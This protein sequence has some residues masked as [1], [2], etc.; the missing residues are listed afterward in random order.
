MRETEASRK[1]R[2]YLRRLTSRTGWATPFTV[3]MSPTKPWLRKC[4]KKDWPHHSFEHI[5]AGVVVEMVGE[6]EEGLLLLVVAPGRPVQV[7]VVDPL[8]GQVATSICRVRLVV[9]VVG[10]AVAL[11]RG[12]PVVQ[13]RQEAPLGT[14]KVLPRHTERIFV[15]MILEAHQAR[16]AVL[17]VD[18]RPGEGAVEAV[19]RAARQAPRAC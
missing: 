15:E 18:P 19:D 16:S 10:V 13:V 1:R 5:G 17:G 14:A 11:G 6:S 12:V 9:A 2:R 8:P 7:Q 4:P 3:K